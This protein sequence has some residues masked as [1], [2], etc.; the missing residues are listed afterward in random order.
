[1][2]TATVADLRNKFAMVSRWIYDGESVK[3][4]KHGAVFAVLSPAGKKKKTAIE[5]PD[6]EARLKK[7]FPNG[8]VEGRSSEQVVSD[9][10]GEY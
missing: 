6:Y 9:I 10:R 5:W 7:I 3:I 4:M 2:K 1:M 8:P